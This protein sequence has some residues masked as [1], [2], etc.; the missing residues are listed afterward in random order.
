MFDIGVWELAL[1]V[2]VALLVVGPEKMPAMIRTAG[3][4]TGQIQRMARDLRRDIEQEA[5]TEDFK[6]LNSEFLAEDQRLKAMA[7]DP[8]KMA[9]I[10]A[11]PEPESDSEPA[12][13]NKPV[14]KES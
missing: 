4:W 12:V 9:D 7:K 13:E 14:Q 3:Q 8:S 6:A 5:H 11:T 10:A 1:I 2:I